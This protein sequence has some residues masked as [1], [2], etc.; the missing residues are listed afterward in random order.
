MNL[1]NCTVSRS[2]PR[3]RK[4]IVAK[5]REIGEREWPSNNANRRRIEP[6]LIGSSTLFAGKLS[7]FSLLSRQRLPL[8][9]QIVSRP[10]TYRPVRARKSLTRLWLQLLPIRFD[11][12]AVPGY[13]PGAPAIVF[14]IV[15]AINCRSFTFPLL[16]VDPDNNRAIAPPSDPFAKLAKA[17]RSSPDISPHPKYPAKLAEDFSAFASIESDRRCLRQA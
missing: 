2:S 7:R 6:S 9:D 16:A 15:L 13:N 14:I 11:N 4:K 17:K 12:E 10:S 8:Q 1:R 5:T 3:D